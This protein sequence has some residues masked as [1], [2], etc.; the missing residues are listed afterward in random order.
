[1]SKIA[2]NISLI[3]II[4]RLNSIINGMSW[5]KNEVDIVVFWQFNKPEHMAN[6]SQA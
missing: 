1:M 3:Q 6:G 4:F 2:F 5:K